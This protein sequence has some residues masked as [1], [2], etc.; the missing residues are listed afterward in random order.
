MQPIL[1]QRMIEDKLCLIYV[2]LMRSEIPAVV[3]SSV[4]ND[5]ARTVDLT[6]LLSTGLGLAPFESGNGGVYIAT[7]KAKPLL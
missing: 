2:D 1:R 6:L 3:V 7:Y 4:Y 5:I